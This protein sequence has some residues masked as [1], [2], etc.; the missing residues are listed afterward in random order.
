M[1]QTHFLF[2][3]VQFIFVIF[4]FL[5]GGLCLGVGFLPPVRDS[6]ELAISER[7]IPWEGLGYL[8]LFLASILSLGFYKIYR[9]IYLQI[10]MD[11]GKISIDL[12]IV[13]G[14][15]EEYFKTNALALDRKIE[16]ILRG[17]NEIE[18]IASVVDLSAALDQ[19]AAIEEQLGSI[20]SSHFGPKH[21]WVLTFETI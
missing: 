15:I 8:I 10:R 16:V 18:I 12:P 11:Q 21:Q 6:L 14:V 17:G 7:K 2:S 3:A 5:L 19:S 20:L 9:K 4:L 1:R 13:K